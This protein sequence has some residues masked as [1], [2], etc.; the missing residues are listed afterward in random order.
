MF[1]VTNTMVGPKMLHGCASNVAEVKGKQLAGFTTRAAVGGVGGGVLFC[2]LPSSFDHSLATLP[3][4]DGAPFLLLIEPPP[5]IWRSLRFFHM[6]HLKKNA[7]LIP[8]LRWGGVKH[9]LPGTVASECEFLLLTTM[10]I[11]QGTPFRNSYSTT[12]DRP[13]L[14]FL[15]FFKTSRTRTKKQEM[16]PTIHQRT[17]F[18]ASYRCPAALVL[19]PTVATV[20]FSG[21][22]SSLEELTHQPASRP[23]YARQAFFYF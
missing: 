5:T 19:V 14:F 2:C 8:V 10:P 3:F 21:T 7:C 11:K 20:I 17:Q 18:G 15:F 16:L 13:R 12:P 6:L 23:S 9:L 22:P 1:S 4:R